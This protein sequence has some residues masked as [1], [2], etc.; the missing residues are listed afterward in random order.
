MAHEFGLRPDFHTA[1]LRLEE[2][3]K[4]R[5][6]ADG[7]VFLPNP[8][9]SGP[10]EYVF[11]AMEPSLGGWVRSRDEAKAKAEA[12]A[13]VEAGY[14]NFVTSIGDFIL[15]F[16]IRQYL[17][18]PD[19]RYYIT[20]LTK[21]AMWVKNARVESYKRYDRWNDL[22]LE[23]LDLVAAS[24]AH[25][26][27]VGDKPDDYL[28]VRSFPKPMTK[29]IQYSGKVIHY[30]DQAAMHRNRCIIGHEGRFEQFKGS[31][32]FKD[33]LRTA[34]GV[35]KESVP[36]GFRAETMARLGQVQLSES[37]QKLIFCYRLAFEK[38]SADR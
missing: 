28:K 25:V 9:P 36:P 31:V 33:I 1:Y 10:V 12:R 29:E 22:L 19:Q 26:F 24:G 27:A 7:D 17:C 8:E 30:S 18:R 38:V 37:Q 5:A 23:E 11:I 6:E 13:K 34:E 35:L 16:S 21:G 20:D 32:T 2:R 3:M 15:H 14:R 4:A